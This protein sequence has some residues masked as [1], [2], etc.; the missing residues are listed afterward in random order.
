MPVERAAA[1]DPTYSPEGCIVPSGS[2]D[3]STVV[4]LIND[5]G[6]NTCWRSMNCSIGAALT[7]LDVPRPQVPGGSLF[8]RPP[9]PNPTRSG[10]SFA[11]TVPQDVAVDISVEDLQGRRA[12]TLWHGVLPAGE[13]DFSWN[14][15]ARGKASQ[16]PGR[17][18]VRLR[19]GNVTEVKSFTL[20]R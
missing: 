11:I 4:Q 3:A 16:P 6:G 1:F 14:L 18:W 13:H 9:A 15:A 7:A 5:D 17:Y 2:L 20:I 8:S 10:V 19:S 12:A